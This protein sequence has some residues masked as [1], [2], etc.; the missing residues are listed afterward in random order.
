MQTH[1]IFYYFIKLLIFSGYNY[2]NF[3]FPFSPPKLSHLSLSTLFQIHGLF[4]MYLSDACMRMQTHRERERRETYTHIYT[5]LNIQIEPTPCVYCYLCMCVF[6]ADGLIVGNQLVCG[7]QTGVWET[8][9]CA[10]P[11]GDFFSDSRRY[12]VACCSWYT[13]EASWSV[14]TPLTCL[15]LLCVF[16]SC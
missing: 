4:V 12:L 8:N 9:W 3:P 14:P 1:N 16:S 13:D 6:R 11:G 2:I 7:G 10:L 5:L 15:L